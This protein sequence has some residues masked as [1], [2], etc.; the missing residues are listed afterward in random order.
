MTE[1][2]PKETIEKGV[3]K[4]LDPKNLNIVVVLDETPSQS[5]KNISS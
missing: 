4:T 5:Q 3:Q 2:E 1:E